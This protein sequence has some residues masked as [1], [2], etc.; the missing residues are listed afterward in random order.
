MR[1][2]A[3]QATCQISCRTHRSA[4]IANAGTGTVYMNCTPPSGNTALTLVA[5]TTGWSGRVTIP[6]AQTCGIFSGTAS[7][8]TGMPSTNP[9]GVSAEW[10]PGVQRVMRIADTFVTCKTGGADREP[11]ADL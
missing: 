9:D 10:L 4:A 1:N 7:R 5:T 6:G 2:A 8:P 11:G 3:R